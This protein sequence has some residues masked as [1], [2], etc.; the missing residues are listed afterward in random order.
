M[1]KIYITQCKKI[2]KLW[3]KNAYIL[4][5]FLVKSLLGPKTDTTKL[6][7]NIHKNQRKR[8]YEKYSSERLFLRRILRRNITLILVHSLKLNTRRPRTRLWNVG[9]WS[10]QDRHEAIDSRTSRSLRSDRPSHSVGRSEWPARARVGRYVATEPRTSWSLRSDRPSH[11]VGRYVATGPRTSR[12][13][14]SDRTTR[15]TK[16]FL[17]SLRSD[18][19]IADIAD[20][21]AT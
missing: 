1:H 6:H 18:R 13:L 9:K 21:V 15:P 20:M 2:F 11:L 14:R 4:F 7:P 3:K 5:E 8:F 12:L 19:S 17:W 16:P 10:K